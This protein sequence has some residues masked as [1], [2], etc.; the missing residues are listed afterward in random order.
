MFVDKK[1]ILTLGLI[2]LLSCSISMVSATNNPDILNNYSVEDNQVNQENSIFTDV[3]S[4]S[5]NY[6]SDTS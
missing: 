2:L 5:D 3:S 6:K 4:I 1:I